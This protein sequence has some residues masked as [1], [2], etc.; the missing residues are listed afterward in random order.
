LS[1]LSKEELIDIELY[2]SG[3]F[4]WDDKSFKNHEKYDYNIVSE[5]DLDDNSINGIISFEKIDEDNQCFYEN[6]DCENE[7]HNSKTKYKK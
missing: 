3:F 2:V 7:I 1:K 5:Y 6:D 4:E